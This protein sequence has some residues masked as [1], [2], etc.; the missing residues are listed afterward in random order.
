MPRPFQSIKGRIRPTSDVYGY[1]L[2]QQ[3][4]RFTGNQ[5]IKA[6]RCEL[7][8]SPLQLLELGTYL[9]EFRCF[10]KFGWAVQACLYSEG[11]LPCFGSGTHLRLVKTLEGSSPDLLAL[12]DD[13][14]HVPQSLR[15]VT[16]SEPIIS[17]IA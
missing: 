7:E 12:K 9:R 2:H 14:L 8:G 15:E 11:R 17:S 6:R 16:G 4:D 10:E 5:P 1:R 13:G 3:P